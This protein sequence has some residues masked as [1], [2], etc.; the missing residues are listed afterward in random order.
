MTLCNKLLQT[1]NSPKPLMVL[2]IFSMY[3]ENQRFLILDLK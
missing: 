1:G 3:S 2:T